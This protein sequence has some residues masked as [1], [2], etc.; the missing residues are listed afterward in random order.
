MHLRELIEACP[1]TP[2]ESVP[3]W[4]VGCFR[5]R[6]ITFASGLTDGRTR[7]VW[8]QCRN[9]TIDL[10]LPADADQPGE[11]SLAGCSPEA[12]RCRANVEGWSAASHWSGSS[13]SWS[14]GASFQLHD[15]WPEP[16]Q[17]RRVGDCMIEFAPSSAYVEDWR[18]LSREPGPLLG[19][20]LLDE[21]DLRTGAVTHRD[22]ALIVNGTWA[23]LV[24]G[25]PAPLPSQAGTRQ[26]RDLVQDRAGDMAFLEQ[27]FAFEAS[28]GQGSLA[29][30]FRVSA[31][32]V[33]ERVGAPLLAMD[34]FT[35]PVGS[36]E[37]HQTLQQGEVPLRRRF[38]ADVIEP[39]FPYCA[40]TGWSGKARAWFDA[41][42][43]TLSR[44]LEPVNQSPGFA[45][46]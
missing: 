24:L 6:S 28:V 30:G 46:Q 16:A 39:S 7:V 13:L 1:T 15:R 40:G 44:Y 17:L 3:D 11:F 22:G 31:S 37:I 38:V 26:L 12:L 29:A 32:T 34:G 45:C 21:T 18:L 36:G 23:G 35:I 2:Q 10:R 8:L 9:L 14:L 33:P 5:R 43:E 19:L 20:R 42:K 27:V 25:R 4:M 41:E